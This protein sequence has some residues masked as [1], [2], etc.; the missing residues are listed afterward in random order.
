[1][2]TPRGT[3]IR[4]R[5]YIYDSAR[6]GG[7]RPKELL[8]ELDALIKSVPVERLRSATSDPCIYQYTNGS[9]TAATEIVRDAAQILLD[10]VTE[11]K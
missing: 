11:E 1:M 7:P 10:A 4:V 2:T 5:E 8:T 6:L 3:L 9:L